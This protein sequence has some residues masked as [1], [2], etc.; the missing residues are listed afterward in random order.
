MGT[1]VL[2][3]LNTYS[4]GTFISA[5]TL[6]VSVLNNTGS[7]GN[8]GTGSTISIGTGA[9]AGALT[10]TGTGE[11]TDR[12]LNLAGDTGG[13]TIT[14]SGVSGN[15]KF[16]RDVIASGAGAKTLTLSGSTAGTGEIAGAIVDNSATG[17]TAL[18]KT[19]TGI[20]TLSGNNTYSGATTLTGTSGILSLTHANA[21]GAT[22]AGTTQSGASEL[23]I[24][25]GITLAAEPISINGG[26]I[27]NAGALRNFADNNTYTGTLTLA[28]QSRIVSD[29]GTLTMNAAN[30]VTGAT[31]LIISGAGNINIAGAIT[32]GAGFI[33]KDALIGNGTG[34]LTFGG[35][36]TYTGATT[37]GAGTLRLDYSANDNSKLSDTA[38]LVFGTA[39]GGT[40]IG[41][42]V[43]GGTVELA[44]GTHAE[45]VG[46]TT[47]TANTPAST[48]S[49]SSGNSVLNLN[50]IT[51]NTGT[52]LIFTAPNIATS[53]NGTVNGILGFWARM[54]VGGVST[55]ATSDGLDDS[56]IRAF[57]GY[58]DI[59][60]LG[61]SVPNVE[62]SHVRIVNGGTSGDIT[63]SG[64]AFTQAYTLQMDATDGRATIR[65]TANTDVLNI[66]DEIG[67]AIWQTA[68]A[69]GLTVVPRHVVRSFGEPGA[70]R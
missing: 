48:I 17:A 62:A 70:R 23:R 54:N 53:D 56:P 59:N 58:T 38:A 64:G 57:A 41:T 31:N 14:Q 16:T 46:S 37:V 15:L 4:G 24:S 36:N 7:A 3:G 12:I 65:P 66:G 42:V 1:L 63:L 55:W 51:P 27:N 68:N 29:S 40:P 21:L 8:L 50:F 49:R 34:T 33:A 44:G 9:T 43:T 30:A 28:G 20:W 45:V 10:Y 11:T 39:T 47:L 52:G 13:A 25:G 5:G 32:I 69:G 35:A 2:G 19:G 18:T 22:T 6:S 67:G 61:G 26:G 60:R